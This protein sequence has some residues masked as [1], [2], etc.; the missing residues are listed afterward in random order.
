MELFF[1]HPHSHDIVHAATKFSW[2]WV[3]LV[4]PFYFVAKGMWGHGILYTILAFFTHGV[5]GLIYPFLTYAVVKSHYRK[6]GWRRCNFDGTL[7]ID[8]NSLNS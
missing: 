4:G 2:L 6:A 7:F 1:R 8:P 3:L 5:S